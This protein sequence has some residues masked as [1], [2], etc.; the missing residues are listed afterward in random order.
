MERPG[1]WA[2]KYTYDGRE[3]FTGA[4]R[5]VLRPD[6]H[7]RS[8]V[9]LDCVEKV[10]E[11]TSQAGVKALRKWY[12]PRPVKY[13]PE[14]YLAAR[15][16][17]ARRVT[18]ESLTVRLWSLKD[19]E[20]VM[21]NFLGRVRQRPASS[22]Q[23][24]VGDGWIWRWHRRVVRPVPYRGWTAWQYVWDVRLALG[25]ID[26]DTAAWGGRGLESAG[27]PSWF[28]PAW[29]TVGDW[30]TKAVEAENWLDIPLDPPFMHV[31]GVRLEP[32]KMSL[33][34]AETR[35][36][37][38]VFSPENATCKTGTW[39]VSSNACWVQP[40]MLKEIDPTVVRPSYPREG[41]VMVH[42]GLPHG[43]SAKATITFTS[44][45]G[46]HAANCEVKVTK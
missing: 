34:V 3:A 45:D 10:L 6:V 12:G 33:K 43:G 16:Q 7:I 39:T 1:G 32:A 37:K 46:K 35:E 23:L 42:A 24:G 14:Q 38:A 18:D 19:H 26:A 41:K 13:T 17:A 8:T 29:D 31:Q 44:T 40:H 4:Y 9:V 25:K 28:F 21:G 5:N 22:P 30:S 20:L 11:V 27:A 2:Y 36:I 15:I